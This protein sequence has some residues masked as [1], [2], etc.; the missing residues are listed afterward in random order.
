LLEGGIE[1]PGYRKLGRATDQRIAVLKNQVTALLENGRIQTTLARSKEIK[2]ITEGLIAIAVRETDNFTSREVKVSSAK[3]DSKGKKVTKT[4]TS[5]NDKKYDVVE[6]EFKTETV[7]V[8]NPSRL[9]ARRRILK[10]VYRAKDSE[11]NQKNVVNKLFND[12]APKYK[13]RNGG[14][15]RILRLGPRRGDSAEM[16]LIE[17][18]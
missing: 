11:G 3:L 5:K 16:V 2:K 14:Y 17:L 8:D 6:R 9:A 10:W 12:I 13:D 4:V 7:T 1:M 18:V 15:T